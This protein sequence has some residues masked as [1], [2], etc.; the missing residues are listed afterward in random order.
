MTCRDVEAVLGCQPG[1]YNDDAE[2]LLHVVMLSPPFHNGPQPEFWVGERVAI[3]AEFDQGGTLFWTDM[4]E[5]PEGGPLD[6]LR[7][8]L[9]W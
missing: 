5:F 8:L 7:R 9:P 6:R 4:C 3:V 1:F 2:A